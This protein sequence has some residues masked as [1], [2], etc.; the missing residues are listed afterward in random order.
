MKSFASLL[1][2]LIVFLVTRTAAPAQE[3]A[4][5]APVSHRNLRV[6]RD[7][8]GEHVIKTPEDWAKRRSDCLLGMQQAMGK[9]PDRSKLPPLDVE[10]SETFDGPTFTRYKLSFAA[11]QGDRVPC[12]LFVPK[13]L[14]GRRVP[15]MLAL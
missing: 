7:A 2:A 10:I 9:L 11:D 15:G 4:P 3:A 13:G 1:F 14:D 5:S 12:Y 8:S 6:Y